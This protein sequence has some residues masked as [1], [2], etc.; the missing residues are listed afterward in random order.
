MHD[1][2]YEDD[3]MF[4]IQTNASGELGSI[5]DLESIVSMILAT[6]RV[7]EKED[8]NNPVL[9]F[10]LDKLAELLDVY[11]D[12]KIEYI[13]HERDTKRTKWDLV[14]IPGSKVH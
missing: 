12:T 9:I 7:R 5:S 13:R 11:V 6:A 4:V 3:N 14:S 2:D 1:D 8:N 10:T